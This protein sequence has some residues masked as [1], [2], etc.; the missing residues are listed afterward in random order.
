MFFLCIKFS[1]VA[2]CFSK[3]FYFLSPS[4]IG[5]LYQKIFLLSIFCGRVS[6]CGRMDGLPPL[7]S[8]SIFKGYPCGRFFPADKKIFF[9]FYFNILKCGGICPPL[10]ICCF[11]L[12]FLLLLTRYFLSVGYPI[13][14]MVIC[15][16]YPSLFAA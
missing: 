9:R 5:K 4:T 15:A 12:C 13:G 3:F 2:L 7:H 8:N 10:V 6:P 11:P 16:A 14:R 1:C